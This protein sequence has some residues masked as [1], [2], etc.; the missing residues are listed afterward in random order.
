VHL[1]QRPGAVFGCQAAAIQRCHPA[2]PSSAVQRAPAKDSG[3]Q[4]SQI[5]RHPELVSF[6]AVGGSSCMEAP[7]LFL[8][9]RLGVEKESPLRRMGKSCRKVLA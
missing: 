6:A 5:S 7:L 9:A 4:K 3:G 2:L 1:Q 8:A